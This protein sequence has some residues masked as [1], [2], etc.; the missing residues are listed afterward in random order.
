MQVR[1]GGIVAFITSKGTMDKKSPEVR[2]YFAQRAE[3]LGAV[4]PAPI[5]PSKPMPAPK[6]TSDILF[7]QKRDRPIDTDPGWVHL[8]QTPEGI[9]VNSYFLRSIPEM[10]LGQHGV[11]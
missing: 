1:P 8:G 5:M 4:R 11:G 10:V 3:L 7:L 2:R 6:V 9:P